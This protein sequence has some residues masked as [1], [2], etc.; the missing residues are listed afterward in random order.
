M[1][2]DVLS[3]VVSDLRPL[4]AALDVQIVESYQ[5]ATVR[6]DP[7]H[8]A[9]IFASLLT[10]A[11]RQAAAHPVLI[12]THVTGE[13]AVTSIAHEGR[14]FDASD[15]RSFLDLTLGT[16]SQGGT[17]LGLAARLVAASGGQIAAEN[18]S[19]Q[20]GGIITVWLPLLQRPIGA[21]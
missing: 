15:A 11:L 6:G 18:R 4:A 13:C 7:G 17:A 19:N 10:N 14:G 16:S 12:S 2:T 21:G 20:T 8:M 1:L 9:Q 5:P 3:S